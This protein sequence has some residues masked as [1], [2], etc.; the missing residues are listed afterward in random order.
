[1]ILKHDRDKYLLLELQG[2]KRND[3]DIMTLWRQISI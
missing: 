3:S 1:M 2:K